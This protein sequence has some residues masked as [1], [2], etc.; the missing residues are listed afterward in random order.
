MNLWLSTQLIDKVM[1]Q[2][3]TNKVSDKKYWEEAG[4]QTCDVSHKTDRVSML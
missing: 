4:T 1:K 3:D 2:N